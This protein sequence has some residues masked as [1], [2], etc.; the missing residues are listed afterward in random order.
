MQ[1]CIKIQWLHQGLELMTTYWFLRSGEGYFCEWSEYKL[2][3][4]APESAC[5]KL[6]HYLKLYLC[7]KPAEVN[8]FLMSGFKISKQSAVEGFF[9]Q[10]FIIFFAALRRLHVL[11]FDSLS[12][13]FELSLRSI[14]NRLN[15]KVTWWIKRVLANLPILCFHCHAI[16]IYLCDVM[17]TPTKTSILVASFFFFWLFMYFELS[18]IKM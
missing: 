15:I 17:M 3:I 16:K 13:F 10:I 7:F 14:C 18:K 9:K 5:F 11:S 8:Q 6:L 12:F 1:A 4:N 2:R